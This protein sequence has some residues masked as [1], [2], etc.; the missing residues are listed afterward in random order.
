LNLKIWG[1]KTTPGH[2]FL[3]G[4]ISCQIGQK[5][6]PK[7]FCL[8]TGGLRELVQKVKNCFKKCPQT[9]I[10][11]EMWQKHFESFLFSK[12]G[13]FFPPKKGNMEP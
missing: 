2:G 10:Q 1:P 12:F 11:V 6:S 3:H 7:K 9:K 13:D 4:K 5:I 8:P